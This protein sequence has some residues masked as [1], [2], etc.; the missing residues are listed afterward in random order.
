M[1]TRYKNVATPSHYVWG[2]RCLMSVVYQTPNHRYGVVHEMAHL[3]EPTPND[4]FVALLD[5]HY[6]T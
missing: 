6:R 3:L 4:R 1:V 5:K 2:R